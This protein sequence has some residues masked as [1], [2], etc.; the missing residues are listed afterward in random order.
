[1]LQHIQWKWK[2]CKFIF[3]II[4]CHMVKNGL[5]INIK[6][7]RICFAYVMSNDNCMKLYKCIHLI[8][9][10]IHYLYSHS[11][12]GTHCHFV[13]AVL[14][15]YYN[16]NGQLN[17]NY[18]TLLTSYYWYTQCNVV[19]IIPCFHLYVYVHVCLS[20]SYHDR[21]EYIWSVS[22]HAYAYPSSVWNTTRCNSNRW[23]FLHLAS[24]MA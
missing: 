16:M 9:F 10:F 20:I 15:V 4:Q 11:L 6:S 21:L 13:L 22:I 14:K 3:N 1:M 19:R 2:F 8:I 12:I 7:C 18:A 24:A 5:F 23:Q 17:V